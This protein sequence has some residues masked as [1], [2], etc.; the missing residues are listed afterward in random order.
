MNSILSACGSRSPIVPNAPSATSDPAFSLNSVIEHTDAPNQVRA[1]PD[2]AH[3]AYERARIRITLR[4]A[5]DNPV[6][7]WVPTFSPLIP[8]QQIST[9][10]ALHLE[11]TESQIVL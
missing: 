2:P 11:Q 6:I 3:P 4:D 9:R 5:F 1:E 8:E 7:N 10:P